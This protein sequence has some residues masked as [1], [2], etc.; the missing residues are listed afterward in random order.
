[1]TQRIEFLTLGIQ[2]IF[3]FA[4]ETCLAIVATLCPSS[5]IAAQRAGHR[6]MHLIDKRSAALDEKA[7]AV[8]PDR[9]SYGGP[10]GPA[11]PRKSRGGSLLAVVRLLARATAQ[12]RINQPRT[13]GRHQQPCSVA[14]SAA[15]SEGRLS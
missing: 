11:E 10:G 3:H 7:G 8:S 14:P 15:E 13:T 6:R 4:F 12:D 5:T 2:F 9:G 1:M